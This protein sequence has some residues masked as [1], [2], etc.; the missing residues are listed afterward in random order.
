MLSICA[1]PGCT[2]IVFGRGRAWSTTNDIGTMAPTGTLPEAVASLAEA[3][4]DRLARS[5]S[6][7]VERV[8]A[9]W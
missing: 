7:L 4:G 6:S 2:T 8:T 5:G 1:A 9:P 3:P